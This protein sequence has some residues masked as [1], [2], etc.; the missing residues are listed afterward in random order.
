[1]HATSLAVNDTADAVAGLHRL[2]SGVDLVQVLAVS[3]ELVDLESA[4]EVVGNQAGKL[5]SA[6]NT[7]ES[8]TLPYTTGDELECYRK[9]KMVSE[10]L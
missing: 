7:T 2:E 8:A 6:L 3:N 9:R 1:M 5:G 10:L 4:L